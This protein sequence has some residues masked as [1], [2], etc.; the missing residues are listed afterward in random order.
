MNLKGNVEFSMLDYKY[1]G[2]LRNFTIWFLKFS[3]PVADFL[4]NCGIFLVDCRIILVNVFP[5]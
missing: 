1:S 5:A 2:Q 4:E 3:K